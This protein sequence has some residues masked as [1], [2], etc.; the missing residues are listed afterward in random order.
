MLIII[1]CTEQNQI[2]EFYIK[3]R[4]AVA[5]GGIYL[6]PIE[7]ITRDKSIAQNNLNKEAT[8]SQSNALYTLLSNEKYIPASFTMA[9][10]CILGYS[11]NMDGFAALKAMLKL[12][13]PV[14]N[15]KRPSNVP[16][17]MSDTT[18]IHSYEQHLRNYYLLHRLF[19]NIEHSDIEKSRQFIKGLDDDK[20]SEAVKR[21]QHQLDTTELMNIPFPNDFTLDNIAST[22]INIT[23]EYDD[24]VVVVRTMRSRPNTNR[25]DGRQLSARPAFNKTR[26]HSTSYTPKK[27]FTN[28]QCHACQKFGHVVTHCSLL[29]LV[30]AI[31]RFQ[32]KHKDQCDTVLKNHIAQNSVSSKKTFVR[33]LQLAEV[34][35]DHDDSDHHMDSDI[36][37]HSIMDNDIDVNGLQSLE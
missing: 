30:L 16:P 10:N 34:L 18:D 2:L 24:D 7:D 29:P 33:A 6:K 19:S 3:L 9:Q 17:T 32:L 15:K 1:T 8:L 13:H 35:S 26:P 5:K 22:I 36:V 12:T 4:L 20:Y 31:M 23:E 25:P 37:I 28:I 27:R 21:V 11:N 14:L